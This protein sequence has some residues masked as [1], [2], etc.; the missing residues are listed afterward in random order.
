MLS[1]FYE[2]FSYGMYNILISL[3]CFVNNILRALHCQ[4]VYIYSYLNLQACMNFTVAF[5]Y[6]DTI[7]TE[8]EMCT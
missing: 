8:N 3:V 6:V 5:I 7:C 1:V 2:M 4:Q